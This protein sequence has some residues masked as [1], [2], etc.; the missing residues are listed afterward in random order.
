MNKILF[1]ALFF[2]VLL[3]SSCTGSK[4]TIKKGQTSQ[5]LQTQNV[6]FYEGGSLSEVIDRAKRKNKLVFVELTADWCAPCKLMKDEVYTFEPLYKKLNANF[7]SYLVDIEKNNGPNLSFLYDSKTVP[8]LLFLDTKGKVL[9]KNEG[10]L[11]IQQML[12]MVEE[13]INKSKN[14]N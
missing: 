8:T 5:T 13:A 4:K 12:D 3:I 1:T 6:W 7:I 9:I 2:N 10:A 11:G 14:I